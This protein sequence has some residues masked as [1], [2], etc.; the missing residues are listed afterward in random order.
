MLEKFIRNDGRRKIMRIKII[1]MFLLS[2]ALAGA[3]VMPSNAAEPVNT[4]KQLVFKF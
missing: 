4:E 1:A 3:A 2:A